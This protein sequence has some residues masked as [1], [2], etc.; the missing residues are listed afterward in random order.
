MD[1]HVDGVNDICTKGG[2]INFVFTGFSVTG[3]VR[4]LLCSFATSQFNN[5]CLFHRS[6]TLLLGKLLFV[7]LDRFSARVKH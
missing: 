7:P 2:D 1:I 3:K 5:A 4:L 6:S